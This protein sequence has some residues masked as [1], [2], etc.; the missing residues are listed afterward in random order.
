MNLFDCLRELLDTVIK[1]TKISVEF[2]FSGESERLP[3]KVK[4][5]I[6]RIAQEQINNI[7][8]HA[9]SA[10]ISVMLSL[11]NEYLMLQIKDDGKGF[12]FNEK[13]NGNGLKNIH[14]RIE[15][16]NGIL[17]I[18]S[19]PNCGC[20]LNISIPTPMISEDPFAE[21]RL[22]S[23]TVDFPSQRSPFQIYQQIAKIS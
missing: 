9:N 22:T 5:M 13:S 11:N 12:I 7:L 15:I 23:A 21:E 6:F 4:L 14:S 2:N 18:I 3:V 16:F 19:A 8:K 20:S 1:T 17:E 10:K